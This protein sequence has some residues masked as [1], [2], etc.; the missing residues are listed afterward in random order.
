MQT[1]IYLHWYHKQLDRRLFRHFHSEH[2]RH[3]CLPDN[4]YPDHTMNLIFRH[5][6][7]D[8][9]NIM[10]LQHL[11]RI[12]RKMII[13][14]SSSIA[15]NRHETSGSGKPSASHS[16]RLFLS[17]F[18]FVKALGIDLNLASPV[19]TTD[20]RDLPFLLE[21]KSNHKVSTK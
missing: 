11:W 21:R 9:T 16:I 17:S 13:I 5:K 18:K 12:K 7:E 19:T 15:W 14:T 4:L 20:P 2:R 3:K 6:F 10:R 8:K 1:L